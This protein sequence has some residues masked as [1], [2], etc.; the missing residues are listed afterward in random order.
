LA[1][2]LATGASLG[3]LID[4]LTPGRSLVFGQR[5]DERRNVHHVRVPAP[6][7]PD[8]SSLASLWTQVAPGDRITVA[9]TSDAEITGRFARV[10]ESSLALVDGNQLRQI[11]A[12]EV[13]SVRR[14]RGGT[15]VKKGL[16]I[17]VPLGAL[18]GSGACYRVTEPYAS[19]SGL[20]ISCGAGVLL[21]AVVG[22]GVGAL[23]G[24]KT[25]G[26]TVVYSVAPVASLR[27]VGVIGSF[28]F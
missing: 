27:G 3:A 23:I 9:T 10:S 17:G 13:A 15:H 20:A 19:P 26:S 5:L 21:G 2:G 4:R 24:G 28:S 11:S 18:S 1:L 16:L 25:W 12:N 6:V 7:T 14:Y 8:R 22:G